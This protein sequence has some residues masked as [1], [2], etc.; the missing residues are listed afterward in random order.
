MVL[1][2]SIGVTLPLLFADDTQNSD[3]DVAENALASPDRKRLRSG[4]DSRKKSSTSQPRSMP[5]PKHTP[6]TRST[7]RSKTKK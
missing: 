5:Q 4:R 2:I 7:S 1:Y 3:E 6:Q